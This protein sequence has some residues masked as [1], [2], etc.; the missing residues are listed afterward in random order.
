MS[1][2]RLTI[3]DL[4]LVLAE[5]EIEKLS[6]RSLAEEKLSAVIQ[7][8]LDLAA[9]SFRGA[10]QSKGYLLDE[11]DH[12]IAPEY[13]Q[14]AL[15]YAR[16]SIWTR[17]PMTENFAL[18]EPRK[19]QY[20]EAVELLKNPYIGVSKPDYS[21]DPTLSGDTSL[22]NVNDGAVTMPWLKLPPTPFDTGFARVYPYWE[23]S[24]L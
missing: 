23:F 12:Y 14:F 3:D 6:E 17:F 19:K 13:M 4:R 1:W 21:D 22:S 15:N 8:Q 7:Q 18:S 2:K 10:L 9:D 11:R 20:D 16:Y 5:D 24:G